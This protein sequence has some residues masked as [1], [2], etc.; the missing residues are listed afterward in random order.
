MLSTLGLLVQNCGRNNGAEELRQ[1]LME[2]VS[3]P[4]GF[5]SKGNILLA[6]FLLNLFSPNLLFLKVRQ[7]C[8]FSVSKHFYPFLDPVLPIGPFPRQRGTSK[9][10]LFIMETS[11]A[12]F[13]MP[14][15]AGIMTV[16]IERRCLGRRKRLRR[17]VIGR[18]GSVCVKKQMEEINANIR[19]H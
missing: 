15:A 3:A 9:H 1:N 7:A 5:Q 2:P 16:R 8:I 4:G 19:G 18:M 14:L 17:R 6:F 10:R 11:Q 13:T 12:V